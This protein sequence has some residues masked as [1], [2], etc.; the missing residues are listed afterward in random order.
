MDKKTLLSNISFG[1][2]WSEELLV[3]DKYLA[4]FSILEQAIDDCLE[5]DILQNH[6]ILKALDFIEQNIE[7][8]ANY[9]Q[10]YKKAAHHPNQLLRKIELKNSL[11][12]MR[13]W[14]SI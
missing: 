13:S 4:H 8:G 9:A 11:K 2:D 14:L 12:H 1:G 7:K 6:R 10:S 5:F 3:R